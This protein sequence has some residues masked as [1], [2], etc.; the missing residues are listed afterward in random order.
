MNNT[1]NP[2]KFYGT[3]GALALAA[4]II[5]GLAMSGANIVTA[6]GNGGSLSTVIVSGMAN[7][8][9]KA[10]PRFLVIIPTYF[11]FLFG[12]AALLNQSVSKAIANIRD[13]S[14]NDS[15]IILVNKLTKAA[16]I[17]MVTVVMTNPANWLI[18]FI[19]K[20]V[21]LL[22]VGIIAAAI[23]NWPLF[24]LSG[25]QFVEHMSDEGSDALARLTGDWFEIAAWITCFFI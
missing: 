12:V 14:N 17:A 6:V 1:F 8:F 21:L 7:N 5:F 18:T 23:V 24:G 4:L 22:G 2:I 9:A 20:L 11:A 25:K 13:H 19:A 16:T 10:W 15:L 3:L